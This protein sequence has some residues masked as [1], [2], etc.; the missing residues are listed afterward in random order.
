M[1][2]LAAATIVLICALPLRGGVEA[3]TEHVRVVTELGPLFAQ[4]AAVHLEQARALYTNLGLRPCRRAPG[5]LT[6]L[7]Y[8]DVAE[9]ESQRP[10]PEPRPRFPRGFFQT[11]ADRDYIVL[12]WDAPGN[13]LVALAH[14]QVHQLTAGDNHPTWFREGLA[15]YLSRW[16]VSNGRVHLGA[17]V[18]S[19]LR[20]LEEED[21]VPLARLVESSD[22]R[23]LVSRPGYYAQ[24]W[25]LVHWLAGSAEGELPGPLDL[26]RRIES[27][28]AAGVEEQLRAHAQALAAAPRAGSPIAVSAPIPLAVRLRPLEA[29]ES[30]FYRADVLREGGRR[31]QAR[32]R[33][34]E[35]ERAFPARPEPSAALG[36]LAM[37]EG[38][39]RE[40]EAAFA[41][42]MAKGPVEP[43]THYRYSL[44][45]MRPADDRASE[46][47]RTR[48]ALEHARL[49]RQA[50]AGEP[51]YAFTEAQ[52]LVLASRW[53]EAAEILGSLAS[54]PRWRER[55]EREFSVLLQRRQQALGALPVPVL[56]ASLGAR[57]E[58][59]LRPWLT[60]KAEPVAKPLPPP[61][62]TSAEQAWPPPRTVV[63]YGWL[64]AVNCRDA[65]KVVTVDTPRFRVRLLEPAGRRATLHSPPAKWR[66]L[67]C[68][69]KGY[70]EVNVA[71]RPNLTK[72]EMRG[73]LAA[74]LF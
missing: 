11:G 1:R 44:M 14:E 64:K 15:E 18:P 56:G 63:I 5:L 17:P 36:A 57:A 72:G 68:K 69:T 27:M 24:A 41:R 33:L 45:L 60:G 2:R 70:W 38:N 40:A 39:Y 10:I 19:F 48:L 29:W 34:I 37:D 46:G 8:R 58:P 65:E 55:A 43:R 42:A 50:D 12:A 22:K 66:G 4:A 7:L 53:A 73:E 21:W 31:E 59:P 16:A 54:D 13:P 25:L 35:I 20:L 52:A 47:E 3:C 67:P 6:V 49:A 51:L 26:E 30:D 62:P 74:I 71:Y 61:D 23:E 32:S 9:M 28:G